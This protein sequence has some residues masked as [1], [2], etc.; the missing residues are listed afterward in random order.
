MSIKLIVA[1]N[2]SWQIGNSKSNDLLY[3]IKKD[4][5]RFKDLTKS[6][7]VVMGKVTFDSLKSPLKDRT[8][9]ILS[10]SNKYNYIHTSDYDLIYH[11]NLENVITQYKNSGKQEKE[12]F[13]I[14]GSEI[15]AQA[16][17]YVDELYLT[18]IHD[19][20]HPDGNVYF[21]HQEL[22]NFKSYSSEKFYDETLDLEYSFIN[23][24]RK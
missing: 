17:P 5:L 23:Y 8:N 24:I 16:M 19:S 15:Y 12:M 10:R 11:N 9:V 6:N 1:V 7:Y 22:S 13:I 2:E 4:L 21:P 20:N 14:G 3:K 18:M